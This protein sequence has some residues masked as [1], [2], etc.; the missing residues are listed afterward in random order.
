MHSLW[1]CGQQRPAAVRPWLSCLS[2]GSRLW[3]P[4]LGRAVRGC[5][6]VVRA[7]WIAWQAIV[8]GG[9]RPNGPG[10]WLKWTTAEA[11][12]YCGL[13]HED[14]GEL[15]DFVVRANCFKQ[16]D[17][18][19]SL[20]ISHELKYDAIFEVDRTSPRTCQ[21]PFQFV[22]M[23]RD[24]LWISSEQFQC[25]FNSFLQIRPGVVLSA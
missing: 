18:F 8:S 17:L 24:V 23:K 14:D 7:G 15:V 2:P 4:P 6:D 9:R 11:D 13:I 25:M 10:I 22:S 3:A 19:L 16:D 20:G 12:F 21:V 1:G 5:S